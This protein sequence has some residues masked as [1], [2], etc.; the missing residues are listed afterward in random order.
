[1]HFM[2]DTVSLTLNT[3]ETFEIAAPTITRSIRTNS[4]LA[5]VEF[6]PVGTNTNLEFQVSYYAV[7]NSSGTPNLV[8]GQESVGVN[9]NDTFYS[10]RPLPG[11]I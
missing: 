6:K 5:V 8:G 3:K 7:M 2:P 9:S 4:D 11:Q 10:K 1:M